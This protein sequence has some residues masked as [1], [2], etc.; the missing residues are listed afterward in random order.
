MYTAFV[1][2]R[3]ACPV[4]ADAFR[5]GLCRSM[6]TTTTSTGNVRCRANG[7]LL[8]PFHQIPISS[9]PL[10]PSSPTSLADLLIHSTQTDHRQHHRYGLDFHCR[11]APRSSRC[12]SRCSSRTTRR[13]THRSDAPYDPYIP[14][15]SRGGPAGGSGSAPQGQGQGNKKVSSRSHHSAMGPSRGLRSGGASWKEPLLMPDQR[16][17]AADRRHGRHHA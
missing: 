15:N 14:A 17:P 13:L 16:Y 7:S 1:W 3:N 12:W 9:S 8:P 10:H 4:A 2:I 6:T 5:P 11:T